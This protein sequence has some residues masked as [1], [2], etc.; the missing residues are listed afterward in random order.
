MTR[1]PKKTKAARKAVRKP[2]RAAKPARPKRRD[3]LDDF[4]DAGARG[5]G[6]KI[7][8]A[9]MPAVRG[10][11]RDSLRHGALVTG[12]AMPDDA[13]PAPVFKA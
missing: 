11:L 8:R 2:P 7:D 5:L 6:L 4:I 9:W 1:A 3:P 13:E 12:F 10:Y